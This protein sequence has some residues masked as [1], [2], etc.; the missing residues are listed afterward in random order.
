MPVYEIGIYN[1]KVRELVE[2]GSSHKNLGDD[3]S[4]VHYFEIKASTPELAKAKISSQ[5]SPSQ[6]YVIDYVQELD[7]DE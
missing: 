3:W 4:D 1:Q 2:E 6:G 5:Y 7:D